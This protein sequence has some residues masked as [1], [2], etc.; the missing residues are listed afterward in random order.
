MKKKPVD[1][2][3]IQIIN[4]LQKN[5]NITNKDLSKEIDLSAGPTLV[6]VQ[7][8]WKRR[9]LS[10]YQAKVNYLYFKYSYK[11]VAI[12]TISDNT[13]LTFTSNIAEKR[14][15]IYCAELEKKSSV[16]T[17]VRYLV[18]FMAKS[19][20]HLKDCIVLINRNVDVHDIEITSVTK[21]L[22]DNP[23]ELSEEDIM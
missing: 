13:R 19:K 11:A 6:R 10:V 8:L 7:N 3:D 4:R 18:I 21:V 14:E 17:S 12:I 1:R 23:L 20:E 22:K 2:V 9:I 15:V 5:A 16:V